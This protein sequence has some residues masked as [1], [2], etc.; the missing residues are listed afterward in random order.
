MNV[1]RVGALGIA[2]FATLVGSIGNASAEQVYGGSFES[3]TYGFSFEWDEGLWTATPVSYPDA[4]GL[5]FESVYSAGQIYAVPAE[6]SATD[7]FEEILQTFEQGNEEWKVAPDSYKRPNVGGDVQ[8]ELF[9][10]QYEQ[11]DVEADVLLYM[12]C[13][14]LADGDAVL[15]VIYG[16]LSSNYLRESKNRQELLGSIEVDKGNAMSSNLPEIGYGKARNANVGAPETAI[17]GGTY[18]NVDAG[19]ELQWDESVWTARELEESENGGEDVFLEN[20]QSLALISSH[21]YRGTDAERCLQEYSESFGESATTF[22]KMRVAPSRYDRPEL[23]ENSEGEFSAMSVK[24]KD[25]DVA[26]YLECRV[27]PETDSIIV[28]HFMTGLNTYEGELAA[29]QELLDSVETLPLP[30]GAISTIRKVIA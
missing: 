5:E 16:T 30:E 25:A 10:V 19:F 26:L 9:L 6:P 18:T 15:N 23:A 7:C 12:G 21:N 3:E 20:E 2:S 13:R 28:F 1:L 8:Y 11:G 14:P 24:N 17:E 22:E 4:E 27:I 29:W